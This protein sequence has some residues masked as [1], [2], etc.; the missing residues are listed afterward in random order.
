MG[1]RFPVAK[2]GFVATGNARDKSRTYSETMANAETTATAIGYAEAGAVIGWRIWSGGP[3]GDRMLTAG[4]GGRRE[5]T[6][7]VADWTCWLIARNARRARL[8]EGESGKL[9]RRSRSSTTML[10][11]ERM[12][13]LRRTGWVE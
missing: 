5:R 8:T 13:Y 12:V 4:D 3:L 2:A 11:P 6:R 10:L 9:S 7:G 1:E